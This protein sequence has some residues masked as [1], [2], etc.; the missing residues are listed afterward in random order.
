M[1]NIKCVVV[2]GD[3]LRFSDVNVA[4]CLL[5]YQMELWGKR[6]S[7][8]IYAYFHVSIPEIYFSA[9][10]CLSLTPQMLSLEST[11]PLFLI[12]IVS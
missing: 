2:G 8:F 12:I 1:I 3:I 9:D 10:A 5:F 11:F 6:K 4:N 7:L